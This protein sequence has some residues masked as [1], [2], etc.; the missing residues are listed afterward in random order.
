MPELPEVETVR[1][2][3]IPWVVGTKIKEV[4]IFYAGIIKNIEPP[5]FQKIL[6]GQRIDGLK[7]RGKYLLFELANERTLIIHL[8]M[9][10]RLMICNHKDPLL[11]HTHLVFSLDN[12]LQMRFVDTRK[13]GLVYLVHGEDFTK[14]SGLYTLGPEPLGEDFNFEEFKKRLGSKKV[15]LK[16]FLLD[17]RQI[18]GIGNIYA[19]EIL[20]FARLNPQRLT[21]TLT[22]EEAQNLYQAIRSR[23]TEGV[24][25]RGTTIK[26]Y[27]DGR[28]EKGQFQHQLK[29]YGRYGKNCLECG[30]SLQ[31]TIVAGRT[32][33]YCPYC[34]C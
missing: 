33:V 2:T 34:Q 14:I 30:T 25:L 26:D 11:K 17:Q 12:N 27:V 15:Q 8:R 16:T 4:Q 23:L 22:P 21:N 9:T 24:R 19:D 13:F 20:F 31:K 3:L 10:G 6:Q 18:A 7:R 32:T 29:V 28:G 5:T 1:R